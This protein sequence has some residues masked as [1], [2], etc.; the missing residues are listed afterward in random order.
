MKHFMLKN[1]SIAI[2]YEQGCIASLLDGDIELCSDKTALFTLGLRRED[3]SELHINAQ[4]A[5]CCRED[6]GA[7]V[8]DGFSVDIQVGVTLETCEDRMVWGIAVENHSDLL[9]E[10]VEFPGVCLPKLKNNGGIGQM[11]FPFN[12]GALVDDA[13]RRAESDFGSDEPVYP[14]LGKY[15]VFPN[16]V[17][18]QFMA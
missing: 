15:N 1:G 7:A 17:F 16:M 2:D 10:W 3:G 12:E 13:Q 9:V 11:L 5:G 6:D 4:E 8:Y 14:S 18:S